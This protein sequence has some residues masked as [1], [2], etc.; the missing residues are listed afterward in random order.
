MG[1]A[2]AV[3][4]TQQHLDDLARGDAGYLS[5]GRI[6]QLAEQGEEARRLGMC[7]WLWP[8]LPEG[9]QPG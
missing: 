7:G 8:Y 5:G 3:R 2:Q 6:A 9:R 1:P 4:D